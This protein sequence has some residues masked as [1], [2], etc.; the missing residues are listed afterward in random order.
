MEEPPPRTVQCWSC[1]AAP[2]RLLPTIRS[3]C[4]RLD[5]F[6]LAEAPMAALL[7][8]WLPELS[9]PRPDRAGPHRRWLPGQAL[10]LAEGEGLALQ[11]LVEEVLAAL[12][13]PVP[14]GPMRSP[15]S[16]PASATP[17]R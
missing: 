2:D 9:G 15:T 12:P 5:L 13:Q 7:T 16:S 17:P 4:R 1:A 10:L 11:G 8:R 14:A 6:P 3:R